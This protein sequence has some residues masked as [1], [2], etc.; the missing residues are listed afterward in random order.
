[1]KNFNKFIYMRQTFEKIDKYKSII[2]FNLF[3][4]K[5]KF[6]YL[7]VDEL[8]GIG[9]FLEFYNISGSY[10][11]Y[12]LIIENNTINAYLDNDNYYQKYYLTYNNQRFIEISYNIKYETV[13]LKIIS[14]I[15]ISYN[16]KM[17]SIS[18]N[19][20]IYILDNYKFDDMNKYIK[21]NNML[22][23]ILNIINNTFINLL[24]ELI[25]V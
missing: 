11:K 8:I 17:I 5:S 12:S 7:T 15:L 4:I 13:K 18:K 19:D 2:K 14:D 24:D 20:N 3:K 1:M 6:C 22:K 25:E 9:K 10:D 21:G 16:N 23:F